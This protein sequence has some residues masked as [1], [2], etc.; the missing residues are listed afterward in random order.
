MNLGPKSTICLRQV[1]I[2]SKADLK[3]FGAVETF[4]KIKNECRSMKA[5]LNFLYALVGAV[6]EVHWQKIA[7]ERKEE[8]LM[9]L[10]GYQEL[11]EEIKRQLDM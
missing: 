10:D 5:S 6:E 3:E 11:Q 8:L 7:R 4:I 9:E 1:G 2:F